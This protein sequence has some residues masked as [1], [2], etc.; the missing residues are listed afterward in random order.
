VKGREGDEVVVESWDGRI[1]RERNP[2]H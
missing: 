2:A 1:W